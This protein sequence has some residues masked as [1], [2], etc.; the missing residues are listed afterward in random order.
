M[1]CVTCATAVTPSAV[2]LNGFGGLFKSAWPVDGISR[3]LNELA[4]PRDISTG[5][6]LGVWGIEGAVVVIGEG[7]GSFC[8]HS[9]S[10]HRG[11]CTTCMN[12]C[13]RIENTQT[14]A[15]SNTMGYCMCDTT[16]TVSPRSTSWHS[17]RPLAAKCHVKLLTWLVYQSGPSVYS[18][19][20]SYVMWM[21]QG[22]T[23]KQDNVFDNHLSHFLIQDNFVTWVIFSLP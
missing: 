21:L 7:A 9:L 20:D 1:V 2:L 22:W 14:R 11:V 5:L 4:W 13:T 10:W 17:T 8:T 23:N 18:H 6:E 3:W 15:L 12:A 19:G 16:T